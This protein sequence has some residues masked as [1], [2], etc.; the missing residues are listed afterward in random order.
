M[1]VHS[2]RS[3]DWNR[4]WLMPFRQTADLLL[5]QHDWR[6]AI[7]HI[8]LSREIYNHRGLPIQF[9]P[10]TVLPSDTAYETFIST[11][12]QVP[13]RDNLHDFFNALVWLTFP[14]IKAQLNALQA[15]EIE[16]A[17]LSGCKKDVR[18]SVRDAATIF[19]ENA[20][21]LVVR[22]DAIVDELRA[23]R[24]KEVFMCRRAAF[25]YDVQVWPFGHA[26]LEKLNA[27]YKAITAHAWPVKMDSTF[28]NLPLAGRRAYLD[29]C[30]KQQ[31]SDTLRT[32]DFTPLPVLG[33]PN[34]YEGQ[35]EQFYSDV[36]VFRPKR[37]G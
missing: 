18:G 23:H 7:N 19:D 32:A 36:A 35:D 28:F 13:T 5:D 12:G 25:E 27:P 2:L 17:A 16:R 21:L 30:I 6:L 33:I 14:G 9:V 15:N 4:P 8:A 11:T 20:A 3:I 1:D 10:Q 37:R 24:W 31:I 26:L 34:W 29:N 22:D